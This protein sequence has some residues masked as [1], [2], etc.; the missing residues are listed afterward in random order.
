[1]KPLFIVANWKERMDS[2]Q[3]GK[4]LTQFSIFN[5]QFPN[6]EVIICPP[7]TLLSQVKQ[8]I[9][10]HQLPLK[11]GAQTI[12]QFAEGAHT[13]EESGEMLKEFVEYVIIGHSE[14]RALGETDEILQVKVNQALQFGLTPI[15]CVSSP[16]MSVPKDV[17]I[18]AYEPVSAIGSGQPDTPENANEVAT[19]IKQKFSFVQTVLYGG[20]VT[21][22]NVAV[23]TNQEQI[24]GVLVGGASLDANSF[25]SII[26]NA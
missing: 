3:A 1:M 20:S 26:R 5:F 19:S 24:N 6:K 2:A 7:F 4:W 11:L 23:F 25:S 16:T 9:Q 22:E 12:S 15:Y 18:V 14:R 17:T 13:G 8:F 21:A 10:D